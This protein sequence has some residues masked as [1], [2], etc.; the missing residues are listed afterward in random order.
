MIRTKPSCG[1]VETHQR[2][3]SRLR[4]EDDDLWLL[5]RGVIFAGKD[6]RQWIAEDRGC[7]GK[8]N[9]VFF[10]TRSIFGWG[11]PRR[12]KSRGQETSHEAIP[13]AN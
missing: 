1:S 11:P 6:P 3:P 7:L 2:E 9:E 8:A 12:N 4:M 10:Q 5:V 13:Q